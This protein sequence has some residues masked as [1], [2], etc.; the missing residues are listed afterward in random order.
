MR[1]WRKEEEDQRAGRNS[2]KSPENPKIQSE[3]NFRRNFTQIA[4]SARFQ[5]NT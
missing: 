2:E 3:K 4:R 5:D 1:M